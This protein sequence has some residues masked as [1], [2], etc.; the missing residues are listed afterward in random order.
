MAILNVPVIDGPSYGGVIYG[1]SLQM[2]YSSEPSQLTLDIV[3]KNG[4]YSTPTLNSSARISFGDFVFNGYVWSYEIKETAEEKVLQVVLVDESIFLDRYSVVL[5]KRGLFDKKGTSFLQSKEFDF[6]NESTFVL[7]DKGS[8]IKLEKRT[9]GKETISRP[10]RYF[11]G[12]I[13]NIICIGTEKYPSS[14]LYG[15]SRL[16]INN[17]GKIIEQRDYYDLWGDIFDNIPRF[18]KVYR[19]FMKKKFG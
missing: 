19:K 16:T 17:E 4:T 7:I 8:Y 9:L 15:S 18:A 12:L 14:I 2:G 13:G 6:S 1:L 10:R 3:S 5:W 11:N